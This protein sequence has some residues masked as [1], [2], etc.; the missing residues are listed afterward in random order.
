[1]KVR[2]VLP[3]CCDHYDRRDQGKAFGL[4]IAVMA[5]IAIL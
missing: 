4:V 2:A 1:M 3:R 5:V